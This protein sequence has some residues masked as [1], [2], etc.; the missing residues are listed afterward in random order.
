M[1]ICVFAGTFVR[2]LRCAQQEWAKIEDEVG[3]TAAPVTQQTTGPVDA[4]WGIDN[5]SE[6]KGD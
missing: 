2:L 5:S 3:D 6:V 1:L 4:S